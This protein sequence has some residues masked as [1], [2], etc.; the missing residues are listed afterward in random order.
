[1]SQTSPAF[2]TEKADI[3]GRQAADS[4][5][6]CLAEPLIRSRKIKLLNQC[7]ILPH[8]HHCNWSTADLAALHRKYLSCFDIFS[9]GWN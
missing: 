5:S 2:Q 8:F 4:D 7:K 9:H 3:V 6:A 1:M